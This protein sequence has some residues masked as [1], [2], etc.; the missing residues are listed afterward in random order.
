MAQAQDNQYSLRA[1][2]DVRFMFCDF[3]V[4]D[5]SSFDNRRRTFAD[6]GIVSTNT[7]VQVLSK[8]GENSIELEVV[9]LSWFKS[10]F[11]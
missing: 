9:P 4:N 3:K 8:K 7:N 10:C 11:H 5:V 6:K 2:I 1:S